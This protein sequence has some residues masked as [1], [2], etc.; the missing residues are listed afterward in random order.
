MVASEEI[1]KEEFGI[2]NT[3]ESFN[4]NCLLWAM[5]QPRFPGAP[6]TTP[7]Y[8]K[9]VHREAIRRGYKFN[10]ELKRYEDPHPV[11]KEAFA[12]AMYE[13]A[14][15][16]KWKRTH[17]KFVQTRIKGVTAYW[18]CA[19]VDGSGILVILDCRGPQQVENTWDGVPEELYRSLFA[20]DARRMLAQIFKMF[21][22]K[23][24]DEM[25]WMENNLDVFSGS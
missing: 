7:E 19:A 23:S 25:R 17:G 24:F 13:L 18:E 11:T 14:R 4:A 20:P 22:G 16:A 21:Q 9:A 3:L 2:C 8:K 6:E 12:D 10:A 1:W 5:G 15:R